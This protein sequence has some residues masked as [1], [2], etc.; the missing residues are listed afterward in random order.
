MAGGIQFPDQ[1]LNLGLLHWELRV[2]AT[3]PPEKFPMGSFFIL[4]FYRGQTLPRSSGSPYCVSP[5]GVFPAPPF[6][7]IIFFV[8]GASG[9]SPGPS[10]EWHLLA[11]CWPPF[12]IWVMLCVSLCISVIKSSS[13]PFGSFP[14]WSIDSFYSE[15]LV[16][17][18]SI[19]NLTYS[20]KEFHNTQGT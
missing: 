4:F 20:S 9:Q 16:F 10:R 5:W 13:W 15:R 19:N 18:Q 2:P 12:Y 8:V 14:E 11:V 3:G 1:G 6:S 17:Q 7:S